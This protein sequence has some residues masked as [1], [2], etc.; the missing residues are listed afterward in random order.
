M[1]KTVCCVL[2]TFLGDILSDLPDVSNFAVSDRSAYES[3][4]MTPM[5]HYLRRDPPEWA[6]DRY[7]RAERAVNA[8]ASTQE[9]MAFRI[10]SLAHLTNPPLA[11]GPL[12]RLNAAF[13]CGIPTLLCCSQLGT[14]RCSMIAQLVL[15]THPH[16]GCVFSRLVTAQCCYL[17]YRSEGM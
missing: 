15:G 8:M 14:D 9:D 12:T 17:T 7:T 2:Q 16:A 3:D 10:K 13:S 5:Q 1:V 4:P 11:V 6:G